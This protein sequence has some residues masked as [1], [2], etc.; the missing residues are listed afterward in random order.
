[1]DEGEGDVV[2]IA[3]GAEFDV[4]HVFVGD[5]VAAEV[6]VRE[7]EAFFAHDVAIVKNA[8]LDGGFGGDFENFGFDFAV[9]DEERLADFDFFGEVILD[10]D[11]FAAVVRL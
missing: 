3:A 5:D 1:M 4:G 6:G 11:G 7:V 8:D 10:G 2:E 9:E